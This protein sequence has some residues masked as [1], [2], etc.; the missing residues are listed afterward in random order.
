MR[1]FFAMGGYALYVW[2]SLL[3]TLIVLVL[4]IVAPIYQ[5]KRTL[6]DIA[7][8]LRRARKDKR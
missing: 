7:R 5:R 6:A 1:E 2:P 8:K 3:L 4:N